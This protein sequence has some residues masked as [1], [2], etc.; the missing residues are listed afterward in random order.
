MQAEQIEF[1]NKK[2]P[3]ERSAG[4]FHFYLKSDIHSD[5]VI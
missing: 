1:E 4:A 3:A 5:L 2:N